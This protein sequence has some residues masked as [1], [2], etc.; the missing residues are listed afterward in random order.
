MPTETEPLPHEEDN[1]EAGDSL[2][3]GF[4][5][6]AVIEFVVIVIFVITSLRR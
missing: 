6:F 4:I 2:R 3:V 1:T 5:V